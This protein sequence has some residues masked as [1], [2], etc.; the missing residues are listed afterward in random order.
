MKVGELNKF[1]SIFIGKPPTMIK[2]PNYFRD[3]TGQLHQISDLEPLLINDYETIFDN[4]TGNWYTLKRGTQE[5]WRLGG[6]PVVKSVWRMG[7]SKTQSQLKVWNDIVGHHTT[8]PKK[9]G[10]RD[11]LG[12]AGL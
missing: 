4:E 9:Y 7:S 5:A 1:I 12:R 3:R 2:E 11:I 10:G 8:N 6:K